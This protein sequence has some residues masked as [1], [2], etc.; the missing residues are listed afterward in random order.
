M[1]VNNKTFF[2]ARLFPSLPDGQSPSSPE[3]GLGE[4]FHVELLVCE[5]GQVDI[6]NSWEHFTWNTQIHRRPANKTLAACNTVR[7]DS[8]P[9]AKGSLCCYTANTF[10]NHST[11][12]K[13]EKKILL[14]HKLLTVGFE[15]L[16]GMQV[17]LQHALIEQH[18]AH[19]L[20]DDDVNLLRQ[21]HLL[22]LPR[23]DD[24]TITKTVTVHQH[25]GGRVHLY[26]GWKSSSGLIKVE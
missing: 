13:F 4:L 5:R 19:G 17:A 11:I 20:W 24:Y 1:C 26:K 18:V 14:Y 16:F 2:A 6:T 10:T 3:V 25:L 21:R 15:E 7:H 8:E 12:K 22:Y 23:D 9:L